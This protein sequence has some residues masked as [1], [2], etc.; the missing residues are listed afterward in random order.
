METG[1]SVPLEGHCIGNFV[2]AAWVPGGVT[3]SQ[4]NQLNSV[5]EWLALLLHILKVQVRFK[6]HEPVMA[7]FR[8]FTG[9]S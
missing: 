6:A 4:F 8:V 7:R 1:T 5:V 2:S 9:K 3:L